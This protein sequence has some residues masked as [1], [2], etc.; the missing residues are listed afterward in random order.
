MEFV[1]ELLKYIEDENNK[2]QLQSTARWKQPRNSESSIS[3]FDNDSSEI[4]DDNED[5][6]LFQQYSNDNNIQGLISHHLKRPKLSASNHV[7]DLD[8]KNAKQTQDKT[9]RNKSIKTIGFKPKR[10][11]KSQL[12]K[13]NRNNRFT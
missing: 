2:S 11:N 8:L 5:F 4:V 6:L 12:Y 10:R 3:S 9:K 7:I 1:P 13:T